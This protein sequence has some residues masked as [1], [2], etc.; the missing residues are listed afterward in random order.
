M[1]P[2][3]ILVATICV[4]YDAYLTRRRITEWGMS[5]ELNPLTSLLC[6]H[7]GLSNG[8]VGGILAPHIFIS[9]FAISIPTFY[10]FYTGFLTKQFLMQLAS[11]KIEREMRVLRDR[12]NKQSDKS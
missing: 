8:V 6:R 10:V 11:L 1:I 3:L 5:A 4:V 2:L 7:L 12:P 9:I